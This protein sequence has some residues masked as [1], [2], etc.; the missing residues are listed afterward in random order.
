MKLVICLYLIGPGTTDDCLRE[1]AAETPEQ[2]I[3]TA[4]AFSADSDQLIVNHRGVSFVYVAMLRSHRV[5]FFCLFYKDGRRHHH[6]SHA[7][8]KRKWIALR[9]KCRAGGT[10]LQEKG[11][12]CLLK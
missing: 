6:Q 7:R 9:F 12:R 3:R 4:C 8:L 5:S 2:D 1:E 11:M 10:G